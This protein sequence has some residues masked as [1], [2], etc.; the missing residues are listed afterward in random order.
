MLE[1]TFNKLIDISQVIDYIQD[2]T[3]LIVMDI[4]V[5]DQEHIFAV[6]AEYVG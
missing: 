6:H 2:V 4:C 3:Q 1:I 5:N